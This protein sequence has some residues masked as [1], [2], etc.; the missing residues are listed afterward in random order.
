MIDLGKATDLTLQ[1]LRRVRDTEGSAT[2]AK[3]AEEMITA[4]AGV[5]TC[6]SGLQVALTTLRNAATA[7]EMVAHQKGAD[8]TTIEAAMLS[9]SRN[10][11]SRELIDAVPVMIWACGPDKLLTWISRPWLTF[12]GCSMKQVLGNGWSESVHPDD[13]DRCLRTYTENFDARKEFKNL[14]RLRRHDGIYHW[15][16]GIGIPHYASNGTFLGY[17]GASFPIENEWLMNV[18]KKILGANE[19]KSAFPC[20]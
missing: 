13:L 5:L 3:Y 4:L 6:E 7:T 19:N 12:T 11:R 15:I 9:P 2:A 8:L 1:L 14:F 16:N 17:V 18:T 20:A 10:A